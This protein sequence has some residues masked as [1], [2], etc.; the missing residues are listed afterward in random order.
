MA[1]LSSTYM[2][3]PVRNPLVVAAS[4][5]T[6]HRDNIQKA[7]D[8]GAGAIV[9]KS[10]F[11]EQIRKDLSAIPAEQLEA[12]PEAQAML[13]ALTSGWGS[14]DYLRLIKD[15]V[16]VAGPV[17]IIASINCIRDDVW[18]DFA[19]QIER[20]GAKAIELNIAPFPG[21]PKMTAKDLE[22]LVVSIVR[23]VSVRTGLPLAVKLSP[24]FTNPFAIIERLA[25]AG[26]KSVVL[27]NRLYRFDF[28]LKKGAVVSGP[29]KSGPQEYHESLRWVSNLYGV[30][31]C[32]L[33]GGTGIHSAETALKFIAA[34]AQTVQL[35]SALNAG[36]WS[37]LGK[38]RD[39][40]SA[41]LD[42]LGYA[43]V[44]AFRGTLSRRAHP[45]NEQYERVQYLKAIDPR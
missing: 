13:D 38:I 15:A 35:C 3:L 9:L 32:E 45:Q 23:N 44:D 39:E 37:V 33:V 40:M 7:V 22:D 42:S 17:P 30:V 34:G 18:L 26:A 28:D 36:G 10:L 20:A 16:A 4:N 29:V 11:E 2:G 31:G 8:A 21:S 12:N 19:E 43:S 27:F 5:L 41:L 14:S 25:G 1:N 6:A 24:Y